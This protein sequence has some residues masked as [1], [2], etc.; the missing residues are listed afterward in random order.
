MLLYTG[1]V[2]RENP[3]ERKYHSWS[4]LCTVLEPGRLSLLFLQ[5]LKILG[6]LSGRLE[7]RKLSGDSFT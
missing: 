2:T 4:S 5:N 7:N 6:G 1:G 3:V